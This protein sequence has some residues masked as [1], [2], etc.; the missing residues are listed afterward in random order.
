MDSLPRTATGKIRRAELRIQAPA[1]E[2]GADAPVHNTD[3]LSRAEAEIAA[4]WRKVVGPV[5]IGAGDTFYD[6]GGDSLSGLQAGLVMER[7]GYSRSVVSATFEGR[8]LADVAA[9]AEG[10]G[11]DAPEHEVVVPVP[12][13]VAQNAQAQISWSLTL[14]RAV[15]VM[16]VLTIGG[17]M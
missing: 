14:T 5:D 4:L 1:S 11:A 16:S 10:D 6:T 12:E 13:S 2:R 8:T 17:T 9:L 15:V 3:D 7:A